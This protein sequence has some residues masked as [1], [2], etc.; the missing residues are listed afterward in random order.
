MYPTLFIVVSAKTIAHP[1]PNVKHTMARAKNVRARSHHQPVRL[2]V[3]VHKVKAVYTKNAYKTLP[4]LIVVPSPIAKTVSRVSIPMA[5][6][7]SAARLSAET[8]PIAV[9]PVAAN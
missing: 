8:M 2:I 3:T 5:R 9:H 7:A 1:G 6:P 4:R